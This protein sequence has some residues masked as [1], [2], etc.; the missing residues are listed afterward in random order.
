MKRILIAS[1]ALVLGLHTVTAQ[2]SRVF[3]LE[4]SPADVPNIDLSTNGVWLSAGG[5]SRQIRGLPLGVKV[6]NL[7][8]GQTYFLT[9]S[10]ALAPASVRFVPGTEDLA[11]LQSGRHITLFR[12][13]RLHETQWTPIARFF[14]A[15]DRFDIAANS[16]ATAVVDSVGRVLVMRGLQIDV[17]DLPN[18][19]WASRF[20]AFSADGAHLAIGWNQSF[21]S[22]E[23]QIRRVS[24]LALVWRQTIS[25]SL[26]GIAYAPNG[27]YIAAAGADGEIVLWDLQTNQRWEV[28]ARGNEIT[29][30]EFAPDSGRL[31]TGEC[32]GTVRLW[33]APELTPNTTITI[34]YTP[35][36]LAFHPVR[37][38][39]YTTGSQGRI[40]VWNLSTAQ[41]ERIFARLWRFQG[42]RRATRELWMTDGDATYVFDEQ[43][44]ITER[45]PL[46]ANGV[47]A[48]SPDRQWVVRPSGVWRVQPLQPVL[49]RA[50]G[51]A[52]FSPDSSKMAWLQS[53]TVV[54]YDTSTW[55]PLWEV[56]NAG[57]NLMF[58]A[59]GARVLVYDVWADSSVR[60]LDAQT[61]QTLWQSP[62]NLNVRQAQ[63]APTGDL[64]A[65]SY[66]MTDAT[67]RLR[68][69]NATQNTL[70][71]ELPYANPQQ[72][73][74]SPNSRY[75]IASLGAGAACIGYDLQ[76]G[77]VL[78]EEDYRTPLHFGA[79]HF[80]PDSRYVVLAH[81]LGHPVIVD[82]ATGEQVRELPARPFKLIRATYSDDG[83]RLALQ[84]ADTTVKIVRHVPTEGDANND[85]CVDEA[86]LLEVLFQF[87]QT[88]WG[89]SGDL[90]RDN[91]V[92]EADLLIVLFNF[93][94]GC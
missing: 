49:Q 84:Y 9:S 6:W 5:T 80:T 40:D 76:T 36:D 67:T 26:T 16:Y 87:G 59:D 47:I 75:L 22:S 33:D 4:G 27:R 71:N 81:S 88:S 14:L 34:G 55:T 86:D 52:C 65:L 31:A 58:S 35:Q 45:L 18:V 69:Y 43:G 68:I 38:E 41:Q 19:L 13:V 17:L 11:Y 25:F 64:V 89:L 15:G 1:L 30:I 56:Q 73:A 44:R 37:A 93:S 91:R 85:G 46:G 50:T 82:V 12:P 53:G 32:D 39:V 70:V 60:L 78:W 72:F 92:D 7:L 3:G 51:D 10:D 79:E 42:F 66:Q 24:D 20:V 77:Q 63:L 21:A 8:T 83:T 57:Y 61:G 62:A 94:S 48:F 23:V 74:F 54:M 28:P 90:N 29:T 2:S